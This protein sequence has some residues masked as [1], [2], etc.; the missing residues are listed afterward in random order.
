MFCKK[1]NIDFPK[2][3]FAELPNYLSGDAKQIKAE[4]ETIKDTYINIT[5]RM[6]GSLNRER[7][8]KQKEQVR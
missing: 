2:D 6:Y 3:K 8:T 5:D 1:F 7:N 4:L